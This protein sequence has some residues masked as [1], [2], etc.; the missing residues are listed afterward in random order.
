[1]RNLLTRFRGGLN[2]AKQTLNGSLLKKITITT[3]AGAIIAFGSV[4]AESLGTDLDNVYHVYLDD[5]HIG[6]VESK[7]EIQS[8][9]DQH[10][11]DAEANHEDMKLVS[12]KDIDFVKEKV[13]DTVDESESVLNTLNDSIEYQVEAIELKMNG[14]SIGFVKDL[15]Q[16]NKALNQIIS[17]YLPEELKKEYNLLKDVDLNE[18]VELSE[19]LPSDLAKMAVKAESS[20]DET[21]ED[22][23]EQE[24]ETVTLND[25]STVIDVSI[26]DKV[27]FSKEKVNPT[28]LLETAQLVKLIERGTGEE[29]HTPQQDTDLNQVA[30][31]YDLSVDELVELNPDIEEESI[32][33]A[34]QSV[35]VTS[36]STPIDVTYTTQRTEEESLDFEEETKKSDEIYVGETK[37]EQEGSKGKKVI[38]YEVVTKNNEVLE[39]NK[40]S[41]E[42]V[43]EPQNKIILEGTKPLPSVGSGNFSWPAVGGYISSHKGPRWGSYHKGMDIAGVTNRSI[44]AADTGVVVE[45]GWDSGGY[46]NKVVINHKNGFTTLYAHMSSLNVSVGQKVQKGDKIGVMGSTGNST[47]IHLHYEIRKNGSLVNPA[48]YH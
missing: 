2:K 28:Q 16:A 47:G 36:E 44:L 39:E 30:G 11:K 20:D 1:M 8:F 48:N 35:K 37:V 4:Y 13:F 27:T 43:E 31:N 46:G 15:D 34:G 22:D 41:E 6:T 17:Q 23:K 5:K 12:E 40:V 10:K 32:V 24:N 33:Q 7:E 38:T 21:K 26:E 19:Y 18:S 9:L 29:V 3:S 14:Q 45:A 25:G 42:V